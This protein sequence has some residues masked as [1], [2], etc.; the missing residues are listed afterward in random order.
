MGLKAK[1]L[2]DLGLIR[3]RYHMKQ[4]KL[5]EPLYEKE[6]T[7]SKNPGMVVYML[8][9]RWAMGGLGDCL[10]GIISLYIFCKKNGF[11][12]KANFCHPFML[13][14]YLEPNE[15]DWRIQP[16]D[17]NYSLVGTEPFLLPCSFRK[18][19]GT[20]SQE[21]NCMYRYLLHKIKCNSN[22]EYH[23]YTNMHYAYDA[24]IYSKYFHKLFKPTKALADA[25]LKNKKKIGDTYISVTLRFQNL[26]GDFFEGNYP[27]LPE[28]KQKQLIS[29]VIGKIQELH[30]QK[31][32]SGKV[33]VTS[34]SRK[35]LDVVDKLDY[36]YTIPGKVVHMSYTE[37]MYFET[38]LKSF[39]DLM[40][41][42]DA[43][44]LYLLV[45]GDMYHS[46]FAE[47][48]SFINNRPYEVI[49]F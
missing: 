40:M 44:K 38:H 2:Y 8:D 39:V 45:T 4:K 17:L 36:V 47:S 12:F 37:D 46:G 15:Y 10:H 13:Y 34:D 9:G 19:G 20:V 30:E 22:K 32:I 18:N 7:L 14:D 43:E 23:I 49:E 31:L 41:L 5:I 21:A 24:D 42:A 33:L 16:K 28:Q 11:K 3:L 1:L 25:V 27:T 35:F 26:L 6:G 29:K 48:A